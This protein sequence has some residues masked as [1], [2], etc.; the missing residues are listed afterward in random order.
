MDERERLVSLEGAMNCRDLG[1]YATADGRVTRW[2]CVYRSDG[3]DQLTEADL[4]VIAEIGIKVV[5]DFRMDTEVD[6][7]PSR[8]PDHPRLKRQRLPIGDAGP[9]Q[10][11]MELLQRG[12]ITEFTVD[13]VADMYEAILDDAA[14]EFGTVVAA[15]ADPGNH[16]VLFH[17]T[18]GKDRTGLMA[19]LL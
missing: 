15:A 5:F 9:G 17:C 1:G 7:A 14:H 3:L 11:L 13:A 12:E 10:S 4:D 8:L 18:A 16:P 19:M 2:G 6:A